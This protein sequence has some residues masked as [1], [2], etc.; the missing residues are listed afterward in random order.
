MFTGLP[1][2]AAL[3]CG[4]ERK[5]KIGARPIGLGKAS[6]ISRLSSYDP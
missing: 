2:P 3:T 5:R 1:R 4:R 6:R